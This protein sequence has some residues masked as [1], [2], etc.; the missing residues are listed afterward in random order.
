MGTRLQNL[1]FNARKYYSETRG[2]NTCSFSDSNCVYEGPEGHHSR[3]NV[4]DDAVCYHMESSNFIVGETCRKAGTARSL[5]G[6][7]TK[8]AMPQAKDLSHFTPHINRDMGAPL[9]DDVRNNLKGKMVAIFSGESRTEHSPW[10][11]EKE[12]KF[13]QK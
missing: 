8:M 1:I 2:W 9:I 3:A 7:W 12:K 4:D 10:T 11:Y 13:C 6:T 5:V